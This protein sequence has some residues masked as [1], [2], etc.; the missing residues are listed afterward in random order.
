MLSKT[1]QFI[2][3]ILP[4]E[5][6]RKIEPLSDPPPSVDDAK[7]NKKV[8]EKESKKGKRIEPLSSPTW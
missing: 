5:T 8:K 7:D 1:E 4:P 6:N 2:K 3:N